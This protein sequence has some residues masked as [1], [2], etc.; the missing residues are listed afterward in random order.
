MIS[1]S[2][3]DIQILKEIGNRLSRRRLDLNRTQSGLAKE[4]GISLRT[5]Q[6]LE[7]GEVA[8]QLSGFI[9][10]CR[11]LGLT[12]RLENLIPESRPSPIDQLKMRGKLRQRAFPGRVREEPPTKWT[13]G[14][15]KG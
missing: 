4:A 9:R 13:W 5:L 14:E 10:V 7:R 8:S 1:N 15:E 12:D 2:L 11:V 3:S 6:R